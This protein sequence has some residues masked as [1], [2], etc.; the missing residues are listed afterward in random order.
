M[1]NIR[2]NEGQIKKF[3]AREQVKKCSQKPVVHA[4][5]RIL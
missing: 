1:Q 2:P 4:D 5:W 3:L